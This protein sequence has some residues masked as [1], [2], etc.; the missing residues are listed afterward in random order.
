M[1]LS[2][3]PH[4]GRPIVTSLT[5]RANNRNT[6][7]N[8]TNERAHRPNRT[9]TRPHTAS[10][11]RRRSFAVGT[12]LSWYRARLDVEPRLPLLSTWLGHI[13]PAT[14]YWYYSDSRVIPMPAASCG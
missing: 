4:P 5:L 3:N 1:Q 10:A 6:H 13:G 9:R 14:T 11:E 8:I 2:V 12:L 7:G